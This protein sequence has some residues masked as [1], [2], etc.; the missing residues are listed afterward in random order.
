[1]FGESRKPRSLSTLN[2]L[3]PQIASLLQVITTVIGTVLINCA[4]GRER[5]TLTMALILLALGVDEQE[6]ITDATQNQ[7]AS[8][9]VESA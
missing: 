3:E 2:A 4:I 1:M 7:D 9:T 8:V 6:V 5:A